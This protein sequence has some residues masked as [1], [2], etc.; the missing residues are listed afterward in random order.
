MSDDL[1]ISYS[2]QGNSADPA[3]GSDPELYAFADCEQVDLGNGSVMLIHRLSDAQMVITPE[4]AVAL[5]SCGVF[6]TLVEHAHTLCATI[7]QLAGQEDNV[8]QVL[9]T[10]RDAGLLTSATA[11]CER[12]L[13]GDVPPAVDLP[14]TR[15]FIITCDRPQAVERQLASMMMAGNLTRHEQL[16]LVDDSRDPT[17]A[18]QNRELV[19]DFNIRSPRDMRYLGPEEQ[20]RLLEK[21]VVGLPEHEEG[22]RFLIDRQRWAGQKTYGLARTLCLLLSGGKRAIVLDDD[23]ICAAVEPLHTDE[24]ISLGNGIRQADFFASEGETV[25]STKRADFDP[26]SGHAQ[27]LGLTMAQ[28]INTLGTTALEPEDL[29]EAN[30]AYLGQWQANSPVLI[31]QCGTV[32]DPG[33]PSSA[34]VFELDPASTLRVLA[35]P[36]GLEAAL[37]NRH[38]WM[39]HTR[40]G[41]NKLA[42]ISQATGLD[43]SALL[44]PYFPAFRGEDYLF[45][46]MVEFLHP[47]SAVLEYDWCIPHF[48]VDGRKGGSDEPPI[49]GRSMLNLP[50]FVTDRTCYDTGISAEARLDTLA[51][52]A[53]EL[54]QASNR[55]LLTRYRREVVENQTGKARR[56]ADR[57]NNGM[58]RTDAW[59]QWLQQSLANVT[60]GLAEPAKLTD[61]NTAGGSKSEAD[62]LDEFRSY[63]SGFARA[64]QAWPAMREAAKRLGM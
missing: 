63:A 17:N 27:C 46:A 19:E 2:Y 44:P 38:Y 41:F 59:D 60:A 21:L 31:T 39:G 50:K 14:P 52:M 18:A 20:A 1:N 28:A 57:L 55:S 13:P 37:S 48:P 64:L 8:N 62:L 43:N 16:V 33:T 15:V 12:L 56:L 58:E 10:V 30:A 61:F 25:S 54:G 11:T 36:G 47:E 49:S 24:G 34:W 42:I 35:N 22:I 9:A 7:P 3:G 45:G 32:G 5:A 40:P 53:A 29:R 4:V 23:T 26:L 51:A 6:R